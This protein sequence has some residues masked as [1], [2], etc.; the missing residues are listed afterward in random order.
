MKI[1]NLNNHEMSKQSFGSVKIKDIRPVGN[2][3][4]EIIS[5]CK[6]IV[7]SPLG[8]KLSLNAAVLTIMVALHGRKILNNKFERKIYELSDKIVA[9]FKEKA[10]KP[11]DPKS[12]WK[13]RDSHRESRRT[14]N[15][16]EIYNAGKTKHYDEQTK[17]LT[18]KF[19]PPFAKLLEETKLFV[20]RCQQKT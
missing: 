19:I 16:F 20:S 12:S 15:R 4:I 14:A 3:G 13:I 1:L 8:T 7:K 11:V 2:V 9:G 10:F 18:I 17:T 5:D 6:P